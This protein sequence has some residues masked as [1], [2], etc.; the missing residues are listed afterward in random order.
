MTRFETGDIVRAPYPHVERA[1][2]VSR[3]ALVVSSR[4]I[5][6]ADSLI[7]CLMITNARRAAWPGDIEIPDAG[8]YVH[9]DQPVLFEQAVVDFLRREPAGSSA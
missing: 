9:D 7:W 1:V 3:P 8:H 2:V 5:G 6:L 4:P